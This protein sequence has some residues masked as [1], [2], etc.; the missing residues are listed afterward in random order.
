VAMNEFLLFPVKILTI[1]KKYNL[2]VFEGNY[3]IYCVCYLLICFLFSVG[4][5][6][7]RGYGFERLISLFVAYVVF[8]V[9]C[10]CVWKVLARFGKNN[11]FINTV[12]FVAAPASIVF[13]VHIITF[14]LLAIFNIELGLIY[15]YLIYV[16]IIFLTIKMFW[17]L[18]ENKAIN[19]ITIYLFL[20]II[21]IFIGGMTAVAPYMSFV[22]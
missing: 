19:F 10:V 13:Y 1:N 17:L 21:S 18:I 20:S 14:A 22:M 12:L 9:L 15:F 7:Y 6:L 4:K 16:I 5:V 3:S 11:T 8:F 2:E